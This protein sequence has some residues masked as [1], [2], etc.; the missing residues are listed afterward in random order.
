MNEVDLS[1]MPL[2]RA[3]RR[4]LIGGASLAV[5]AMTAVVVAAPALADDTTTTPTPLPTCGSTLPLMTPCSAVVAPPVAGV[6]AVTLPG[7]GTLSI[8]IDPITNAVTVASVSGL[9]G[10][11][12]S[13]VKVD[14]DRDKV[15]VTFTSTTDPAQ[16]YRLK[17]SVKA[18]AM[19]GGAPTVTA[20]LKGAPKKEGEDNEQKGELQDSD[21]GSGDHSG[22]GND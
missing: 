3:L 7:I 18:P 10:F 5:A 6:Y 11:T 22:G 14:G 15:A 12:A 8:T 4:L 19:V 13:A 1:R 17:V 2:P 21:V 20:K 16:V 9:T